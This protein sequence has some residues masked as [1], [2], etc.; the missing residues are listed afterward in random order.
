[1]SSTA[2]NLTVDVLDYIG[3]IKLHASSATEP[4]TESLLTELITALRELDDHPRTVLTVITSE[5][6]F[7]L[8]ATRIREYIIG[9]LISSNTVKIKQYYMRKFSR[10]LLNLIVSHHKD[11]AFALDNIPVWGG[12]AWVQ[13]AV[14]LLAVASRTYIR[15]GEANTALES[16]NPHGLDTLGPALQHLLED[17]DRLSDIAFSGE[18]TMAAAGWGTGTVLTTEELRCALDAAT[19]SSERSVDWAVLDRFLGTMQHIASAGKARGGR[20]KSSL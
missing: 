13:G 17:I 16:H 15:S 10:E 6:P 8:A 18:D 1:M 20:I 7:R 19:V 14:D 9:P 2:T 11:L 4:W 5:G 3:V 12:P